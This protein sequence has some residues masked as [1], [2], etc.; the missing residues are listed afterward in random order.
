MRCSCF[1]V[2]LYGG[3]A[4]RDQMSV[5]RR[6]VEIGETNVSVRPL[7]Y[8]SSSVALRSMRRSD[9]GLSAR[10]LWA[11]DSED[12]VSEASSSIRLRM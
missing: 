9:A 6:G 12:S 1:S 3:V 11:D 7:S 5:C 10:Q 2:C 8:F 4:R